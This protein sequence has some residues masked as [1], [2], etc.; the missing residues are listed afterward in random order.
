MAVASPPFLTDTELLQKQHIMIQLETIRETFENYTPIGESWAH[1]YAVILPLVDLDDGSGP[2]ILYEVR[3][4][5]LDRQPGEICFP[6]G[7]IED[8]ETPLEAALRETGEELGIC[9]E[10]IETVG[11][12][13]TIG[14]R[15]GS[16]IHCFAGII[17]AE[18]LAGMDISSAE[19]AEVFTVPVADLMKADWEVY[20][21]DLE[22][23]PAEDFPYDRV[24]SGEAY[25]WK[26]GRA[27]VPVFDVNGW[28]IWGLTGRMTRE[29]LEVIKKW[30]E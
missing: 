12:V 14:T 10:N 7:Q 13:I 16:Q 22:E 21:N 2:Q 24:T 29:F 15:A 5:D 4:K 19:V 26:K 8:G 27:P 28:I 20:W 11:E 23:V 9:P 6:G 3:A 1:H 17:S 25:K 30:E 18:T